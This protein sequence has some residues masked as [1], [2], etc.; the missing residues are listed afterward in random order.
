MKSFFTRRGLCSFVFTTL[1]LIVFSQDRS[2]RFFGNGHEFPGKDRVKVAL[3]GEAP[4]NVSDDFTI[5]FWLKCGAAENTGNVSAADHGDGWITG[6]VL[7]DRD[8]YGNADPGDFGISIGSA[9]GLPSQ[10]RV[11]AFGVNRKGSGLTILGKTNIADDKWHHIALTRDGK[12]GAMSIFIDGQNDVSGPGPTGNIGYEPRRSSSY[13]DSDPYF[14]IGAEKHDGG[15]AYP[16]FNGYMDELRV[17]NTVRYSSAFTKPSGTFKADDQTVA[18][19]HF[20]EGEGAKVKDETSGNDGLVFSGG[21]PAGPV[22]MEDSPFREAQNSFIKTLKAQKTSSGVLLK[23]QAENLSS[24]YEIQR[25]AD[26]RNFHTIERWAD[27]P[28]IDCEH[29]YY[30]RDPL[31]GK[32]FYRIKYTSAS[33]Q[34][35]STLALAS[36]G[37]KTSPYQLTREGETLVVR[38]SSPIENIVVWDNEG[39]RLAERNDL[40]GGTTRL[41]LNRARG[42]AYIHITMVDG[43]R[44]TERI[45]LGQ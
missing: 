14:V 32:N 45:L 7:I 36:V 8:V 34:K 15:Q 11:L 27:H 40:S 16:S 38:N 22:W 21:D 10:F 29:S 2:L 24:S 43:S 31:E 25:S 35:F 33:G 18:L 12:T 28:C 41:P 26:G 4:I 19:F 13:P 5:E 3:Q 9:P 42:I 1:T 20:D 23:W 17:S 44:Y 30:D 37:Q 39:K 6:N